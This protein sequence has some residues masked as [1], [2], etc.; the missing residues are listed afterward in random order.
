[1]Q[2]LAQDAIVQRRA[3]TVFQMQGGE[4][5]TDSVPT[6]TMIV[7]YHELLVKQD[8]KYRTMK[9]ICYHIRCIPDFVQPLENGYV[10][11]RS[12]AKLHVKEIP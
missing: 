3:E 10:V 1:M 9:G 4:Q 11:E 6:S 5:S 12:L 8:G 7:Q 2:Q